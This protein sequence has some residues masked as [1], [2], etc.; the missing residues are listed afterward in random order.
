MSFHLI[1]N[2]TITTAVTTIDFPNVF[3]DKYDCYAVTA[4]GF[5]SSD[6]NVNI[7]ECKLYDTSGS[8]ITNSN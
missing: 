7:T 6:S 2:A 1:S 3:T 5:T 4:F 8:I